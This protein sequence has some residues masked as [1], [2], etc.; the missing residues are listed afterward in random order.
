MCGM[1]IGR[2]AKTTTING[3]NYPDLSQYNIN[4]TNVVVNYGDWMN[5]HYCRA[6]GARAARVEPGYT[7]GGIAA[8]RDHS[9]D[10]VHCME[11]IP[12]DQ[13]IGGDQYGVKGLREVDGVTVN[14]PFTYNQTEVT[15]ATGL[16]AAI[17]AGQ[18]V[19]LASDVDCG[20]TQ[21]ALDN[22]KIDLNG[23][24]LTTHMTY[25]GISMKNGASIK[26][27]TIEHAATV[28]AIKAYNVGS[29]E[30]V[31]I[32]TTCTTP[33]KTITAIAIQQGGYVGTIKNVT[34]EG[35]SQGIEVGYQATV[36]VI[37][38]V[39]VDMST[40]GTAEG[41]GL[42]INGGKVGKAV[43]STF[44]GDDYGVKML[45]KGVFNVGLELVDCD[46]TGTTASISAYDEK[47][48]SN[49]SGSLTLTYDAATT[50]NGPFIWDFE[51]ECLS[52]VTLNR[53]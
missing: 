20:T 7:Y 28:A 47:G 22:V 25:G 43:N 42:V 31:T 45:L 18:N 36:D 49:T 34:I 4:C 53:P 27:G 5:Y 41:I 11:C 1:V 30:D 16:K 52:V 48:I 15:D 9:L 37:D 51:D 6:N 3:S 26:N 14:Y 38:N 12:F 19:K 24:T 35:V 13:L 50:L 29:I 17:D 44:T 46:V 2:C 33:N 21:L 23:K 10:V 8:D 40:N 39:S 32:K